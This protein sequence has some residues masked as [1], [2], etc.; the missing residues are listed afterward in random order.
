V[1]DVKALQYTTPTALTRD[2]KPF[3]IKRVSRNSRAALCQRSLPFSV[4][5]CP[6]RKYH[7]LLFPYRIGEE[8]LTK[9]PQCE[10]WA[11]MSH[12]D[13]NGAPDRRPIKVGEVWENPVTGERSVVLERPWDNPASRVTG[14][15]D[16][17][18]WRA[19]DGG[20]P[21]SCSCG[22][23][24]RAG[25]GLFEIWWTRWDSNPRPPHCERGITKAKTR[26]H[27]HLAF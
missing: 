22:A 19:C 27:N 25:G 15:A 2:T 10:T 4:C 13:A 9:R 24:H 12:P 23:I 21:P 8:L 18:R 17:T 20:T 1:I 16:S 6:L 5:R 14:R 26:R 7:G 3:S 11:R